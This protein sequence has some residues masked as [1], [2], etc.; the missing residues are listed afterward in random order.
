VELE[1]GSQVSPRL[2]SGNVLVDSLA[3]NVPQMLDIV[4][5]RGQCRPL[6]HPDPVLLQELLCNSNRVRGGI[7]LLKH[8]SVGSPVLSKE[9]QQS[10]VEHIVDVALSCKRAID[11]QL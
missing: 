3:Q 11:H 6:H 4:N 2:H 8:Q 10:W 7:I 9:W 5:V 1:G